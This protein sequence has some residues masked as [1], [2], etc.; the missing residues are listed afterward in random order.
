M[1]WTVLTG[2][3]DTPGSIKYWVRHDSVPVDYIL[4]SAQAAIYSQLRVRQMLKKVDGTIAEGATTLTLPADFLEP[5]AFYLRGDRRQPIAIL[6]QQHYESRIGEE[7]DGSLPEG[8]P[9]EC[10]F[11]GTTF[12]FDC[13][14]DDDYLY[15]LWYWH[16]PAALS[17]GNATNFLTSRYP[18]LLEAYL[19]HYAWEDRKET[20]L[21]DR[22]LKQALGYLATA[23]AEYDLFRQSI[24]TELYWG[25]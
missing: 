20:G 2:A 9:T 4:E 19:K 10:T 22:H 5:E 7:Q 17:G 24:R 15:R 14:A 13:T 23:N 25:R 11:D 18:Q 21:A 8:T 16:T 3:K 6:D 12:Y 1:N